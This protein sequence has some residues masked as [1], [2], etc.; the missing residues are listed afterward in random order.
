MEKKLQSHLLKSRQ[1]LIEILRNKRNQ[2]FWE[3][4]K[5]GIQMKLQNYQEE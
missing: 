2:K 3:S 5:F 4:M 1:K